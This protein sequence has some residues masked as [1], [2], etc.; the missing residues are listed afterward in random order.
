MNNNKYYN[1]FFVLSVIFIF[2]CL[3][4]YKYLETEFI[5]I[6]FDSAQYAS[7]SLASVWTKDFWAA[8]IPPLYPF[9][10]KYFQ[11]LS[12]DYN[13]TAINIFSLFSFTPEIIRGLYNL[14][15]FPY[16]L[17]KDN[18]NVINISQSQ[19]LFSISSWLIFAY[20]FSKT[21][22]SPHIKLVSLI[23][24]LFLGIE[25]SITIWDKHI[26][27]ESIAISLLLLVI[28]LLI[29]MP[30]IINN[31]VVLTL[32]LLLLM[33]LSFIKITNNYFLLLLIPLF[34]IYL[35]KFD[36]K[37]KN[38]YILII[39]TLLSLFI[40]NQYTLFKGDRTHVPM[41]DLIS[42]RISTQGYEDIYIYFR[43]AG[44]PNVPE[45]VIG[46]LW[47]APFEDYPDLEEWWLTKSSKTYQKYLVTHPEYF[48]IRPFQYTN[49]LNKPVYS[50]FTPDLHYHEQVVSNK[51]SIIFTDGFLWTITITILL[52]YILFLVKR[53]HINKHSLILPLFILFS[54]F[55]LYMIIWHADLGELDRHLIQCALMFRIGVIMML[56]VFLDNLCNKD[57][58]RKRSHI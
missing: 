25:S 32:F 51:I 36:I 6:W 39:F 12:I 28:S 42:S 52:L 9:F 22:E 10:L 8:G 40:F 46:K 53:I 38:K 21:I 34:S 13:Q 11:H 55:I 35:F 5:V 37:N 19:L 29:H 3:R 20:S 7:V 27:T 43:N 23:L 49:P 18:F 14:P 58:F 30:T 15:D 16:Y 57:I 4:V 47:T 44:M 48:F 1:N 33:L 54:G 26:V 45:V 31:K 24:L 2:I 56:I 41:K 17:V 50:Y